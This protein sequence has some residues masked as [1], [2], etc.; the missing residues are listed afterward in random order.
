MCAS[1]RRARDV[2]AQRRTPPP[3]LPYA[4]RPI[5]S[6]KRALGSGPLWTERLP[7][8]TENNFDVTRTIAHS[9]ARKIAR[10]R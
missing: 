6:G 4:I 10:K 5:L 3:P 2:Y 8:F 7:P 9:T 1:T